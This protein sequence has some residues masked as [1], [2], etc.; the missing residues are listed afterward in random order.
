M[1]SY[2]YFLQFF[3]TIKTNLNQEKITLLLKNRIED[4]DQEVE[5]IKKQLTD[6]ENELVDKMALNIDQNIKDMILDMI[7]VNKDLLLSFTKKLRQK[8]LI[9]K[10]S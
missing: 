7:E 8:I 2:C 9:L 5:K 6:D 3:K 4:N 1:G 10:R